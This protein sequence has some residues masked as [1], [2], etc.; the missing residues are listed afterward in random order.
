MVVAG[1]GRTAPH[2]VAITG[3]TGFLGSRL[4]ELLTAQGSRVIALSRDPGAARRLFAPARFPGLQVAPFDP[5][6][7]GPWA[8]V[9]E[10]V[11]A[12]VHLAGAPIAGRWTPAFRRAILDS[13]ERGTRSIV[14]AIASLSRPPACLISASAARFYGTSDRFRFDESSPPG[15]ASD[16]LAQ[17]CRV[18]ERE[19]G[20]AEALGLRTVILRF[21]IAI[22]LAPGFREALPILRPFMGGRIG[23]GRQWVSWIHRE[24]AAAVILR[25]LADPAMRGAY[26][27]TAPNPVRMAEVTR[28]FG[29]AAGGVLPMPVPQFVIE[30]FLG[31]GATIILDSQ[32]VVP[33]RLLQQ[34]FDFRYPQIGPAVADV[35][36]RA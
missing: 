20:A 9:L 12:V 28:A 2:S 15:P 14:Q 13:R 32:C 17:V 19:A 33:T 23:S 30:R 36:R 21:G 11:D 27:T 18:W 26:N 4:A 10:G 25:A 31:D 3:A 24:D 29:Q 5:A 22:G 6:G 35:L 1:D 7:P 16:Y 8:D 34:G